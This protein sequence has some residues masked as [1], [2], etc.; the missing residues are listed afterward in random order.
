MRSGE[1][2]KS[3]L[4]IVRVMVSSD[5]ADLIKVPSTT[6]GY[7]ELLGDSTQA[8]QGNWQ[9]DILLQSLLLQFELKTN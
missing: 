9:T 3:G 8:K 7:D 2:C 1:F 6:S 4:D 5:K